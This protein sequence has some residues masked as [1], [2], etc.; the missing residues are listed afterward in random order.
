MKNA[1]KISKK[2]ILENFWEL[3]KGVSA[4]EKYFLS[5]NAFLNIIVNLLIKLIKL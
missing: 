5:I 3:K 2:L 4:K 1:L